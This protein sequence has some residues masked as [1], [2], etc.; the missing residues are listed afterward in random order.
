MM[1]APNNTD[2]DVYESA[3]DFLRERRRG[4]VSPGLKLRDWSDQ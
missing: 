4:R 1:A 2:D 3:E